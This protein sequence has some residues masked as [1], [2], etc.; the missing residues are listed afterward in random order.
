MKLLLLV[1]L[2]VAA[3]SAF[4]V[5][6]TQTNNHEKKIGELKAKMLDENN[7]RMLTPMELNLMKDGKLTF[8]KEDKNTNPVVDLLNLKD[9]QYFGPATVGNK[10]QVFSVVYD[11]GS[12]WFWVPKF[13]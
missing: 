9:I 11:T 10:A 5:D 8:E 1:C 2:L 6:L 4:R 3:G 13:N 12:S 7:I